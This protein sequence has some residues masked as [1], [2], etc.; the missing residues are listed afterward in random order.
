M[1]G[2]LLSVKDLRQTY[3]MDELEKRILSFVKANADDQ[4]RFVIDLCNQNSYTNNKEGSD[5]VAGMILEAL[6]DLFPEHRIVEQDDVGNHHIFR[7]TNDS[8]AI[9]LLGHVDTVFP[10]DH[11]FQ[12]CTHDGDRL[13]GPGTGDMKGGLSVFVYALKALKE[14]DALNSLPIVLILN[15]DEEIGSPTSRSIYLEERKKAAACLAAECAGPHGEI[16]VSRNGKVG[17]RIDCWGQDRHVGMGTHKKASAVLELA[18]KIVAVE[19]LNDCLSGVSINVGRLSGG[20]GPC[21][22]PAHAH[23]LVDVRWVEEGH[24]D[25]IVRHIE[26]EIAQPFQ[27]GCTSEFTI[28]NARPAMPTSQATETMFDMIQEVGRR[29]DQIIQ[30]TH[31]R[32]TSDANFFG[33]MGIPTIDGWG[34]ICQKDHTPDE[35]IVISSLSQRTALLSHFLLEYGRKQGMI[36]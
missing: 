17:A 7:N 6:G 10:Q 32:G 27:S 21:T 33:A 16:V 2:H 31:R 3:I 14:V 12:E 24:R 8:G 29:L 30:T 5:R 15:S 9:Y 36:S 34:P 23:C 35:S 22:I 11:P 25:I 13:K 19:S 4:L 1:I 18:Q 20:L 28:L 26:D